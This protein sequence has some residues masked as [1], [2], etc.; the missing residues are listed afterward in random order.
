M[1]K[2][3]LIT[4]ILVLILTVSSTG[5]TALQKKFA[6]K[7]KKEEKIKPIITTYDYSKELRV[8][9][10]YK[11]HFL[12]WKSWH[13][14]LMDRLDSTR[15]KRISCYD[16]TVSSLMEIRKYLVGPKGEELDGFITEVTSIDSD[17]KKRRLSKSGKYRIKKL[18]ERTKRQIDKKFSYS[19]VK[20]FLE[21]RK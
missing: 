9:E 14:E 3:K 18:L 13:T 12:F 8:D 17:I 11:K 16:Y 20:D 19:K 6:R 2:R 21:L 7:K 10:L 5:C 15:K 1:L 4:C